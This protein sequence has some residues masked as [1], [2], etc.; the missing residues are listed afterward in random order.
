[1][2]PVARF[3]MCIGKWQIIC[4]RAP[5][6]PICHK[7]RIPPSNCAVQKEIVGK[8]APRASAFDDLDR[9]EA[10]ALHVRDHPLVNHFRDARAWSPFDLVTPEAFRQT[11]FYRKIYQPSGMEFHLARGNAE[12]TA[13]GTGKPAA[14]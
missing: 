9:H 14:D 8:I 7:R 2:S 3:L 1:M 6:E 12:L 11:T 13:R 10:F 5:S 4:G